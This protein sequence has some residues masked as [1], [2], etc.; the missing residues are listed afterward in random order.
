M[1]FRFITQGTK[2]NI[3]LKETIV[4][5]KQLSSCEFILNIVAA[6]LKH[7]TLFFSISD[8][9]KHIKVAPRFN[10]KN[11]MLFRFDYNKTTNYCLAQ[12]L[13]AP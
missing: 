9:V 4:F 6:P 11:N 7:L 2:E 8:R 13:Q 5:R 3:A 10:N 1:T 12:H